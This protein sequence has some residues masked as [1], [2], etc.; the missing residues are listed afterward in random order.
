MALLRVTWLISARVVAAGAGCDFEGR[1]GKERAGFPQP[2]QNKKD[3]FIHRRMRESDAADPS[4]AFP[5]WG[6]ASVPE[7]HS[8]SRRKMSWGRTRKKVMG[9]TG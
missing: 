9:R 3:G 7:K 8:R 1:K 2:L 4:E 6:N 5:R